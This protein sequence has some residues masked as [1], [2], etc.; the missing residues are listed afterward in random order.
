[1]GD[2][3]TLRSLIHRDH[4]ISYDKVTDTFVTK[5]IPMKQYRAYIDGLN[6]DNPADRQTDEYI[7]AVAKLNDCWFEFSQY[8]NKKMGLVSTNI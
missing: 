6:S 1:M 4:F 8:V 3:R 2:K 7:R 5:K